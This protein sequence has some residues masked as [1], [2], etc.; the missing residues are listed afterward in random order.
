MR[1]DL[2]LGVFVVLLFAVG[3]ALGGA[4]AGGDLPV[5]DDA[6]WFSTVVGTE[7]TISGVT[8][9]MGVGDDGGGFCRGGTRP[10]CFRE[11]CE[12]SNT[13]PT[14]DQCEGK[15]HCIP[16]VNPDGTYKCSPQGTCSSTPAGGGGGIVIY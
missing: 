11:Q 16:T 1:K 13:C 5:V 8:F 2:V 9:R 12:S 14:M 3:I 15:A 4:H 6:S 7:E 10:R